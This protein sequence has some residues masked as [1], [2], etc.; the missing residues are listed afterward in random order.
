MFE[1]ELKVTARMQD[2]AIYLM[3]TAEHLNGD[4]EMASYDLTNAVDEFDIN[5]LEYAIDNEKSAIK[6]LARFDHLLN[7]LIFQR[8]KLGSFTLTFK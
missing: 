2:L 1:N 7:Q 4:V 5:E 8:R 6:E 3:E